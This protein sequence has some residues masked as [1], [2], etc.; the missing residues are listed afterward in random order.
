MATTLEQLADFA[1]KIARDALK[2]TASYEDA[3]TCLTLATTLVEGE[4]CSLRDE[5]RQSL[6]GAAGQPD[7]TP[8]PVFQ[9]RPSLSLREHQSADISL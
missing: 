6:F 8:L 2:A 5:R 7:K 4:C 1:A 9:A 3:R